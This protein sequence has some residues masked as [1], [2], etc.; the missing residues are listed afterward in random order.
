MDPLELYK[1]AWTVVSRDLVAWFAIVLAWFCSFFLCGLGVIFTVN[2]TREARAAV[3]EGRGPSLGGLFSTANLGADL[4][5]LLI[6]YLPSWLIGAGSG[7]LLSIVIT[8]ALQLVVPLVA[9]GRYEPMDA[10]KLSAK[11][12]MAHWQHHLLFLVAAFVV[13]L[14]GTSFV[15]TLPVAVAVNAVAQWLLLADRKGEV[16][17][18]AQEAGIRQLGGA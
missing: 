3:E 12:V 7:G 8:L 17:V 13:F 14:L 4:L 2:L 10:A 1:R 6:L 15:V 18:M 9:E 16:D 5:T 11:H